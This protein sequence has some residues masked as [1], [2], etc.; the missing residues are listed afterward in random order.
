MGSSPKCAGIWRSMRVKTNADVN[1]PDCVQEK[2]HVTRQSSSPRSEH[3]TNSS[4]E[5]VAY[6][7]KTIND[8]TSAIVQDQIKANTAKM[9]VMLA[10]GEQR[11]IT[12]DLPTDDCTV[13]DLLEQL[14]ISSGCE[15]VV[16]LVDD[17]T[18]GIN[19]IVETNAVAFGITHDSSDHSDCNFSQET[20]PILV[21]GMLALCPHCGYSSLHFNRCERCN[22]KLTEEVKSI[23]IEEKKATGMSVDMFYKKNN[24]RKLEKAERDGPTSKRPKGKGKGA[25]SKPKLIHKEP[26]CLTISSDEEEEGRAKK[27]GNINSDA[28]VGNAN[29]TF[30]EE[31]D[32]I[33]DKEPIITNSTVSSSYDENSKNNAKNF[34]R[35]FGQSIKCA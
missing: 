5:S 10:S 18:L 2:G 13:H 32:T 4:S 7:Q 1:P 34:I 20:A 19:Y 26:E 3:E 30:D 15:T 17:P 22:T 23:P 6:L 16:S 24:E 14:S 31:V 25:A 12:F 35:N 9:L 11:L 27:I 29:N 8:P 28:A 21:K 33:L